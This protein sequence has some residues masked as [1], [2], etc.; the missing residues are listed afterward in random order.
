M[1]YLY[2]EKLFRCAEDTCAALRE[3]KA[4]PHYVKAWEAVREAAIQVMANSPMAHCTLD[5]YDAVLERRVI[6]LPPPS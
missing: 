6:L 5:E 1:N 4:H 3:A 2:P